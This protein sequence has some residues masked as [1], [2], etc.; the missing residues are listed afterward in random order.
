MIRVLRTF[1]LF[2][3]V[4]ASLVSLPTVAHAD[5]L[6]CD[7]SWIAAVGQWSSP[8]DWSDGVPGPTEVACIDLDVGRPTIDVDPVIGAL[9]LEHGI[10]VVSGPR[11]LS[12]ESIELTDATIDLSGATLTST[13]SLTLTGRTGDPLAPE[14]MVLHADASM[15]TPG[16]VVIQDVLFEATSCATDDATSYT[17]NA[18]LAVDDLDCIDTGPGSE[19]LVT[20]GGGS[21]RYTGLSGALDGGGTLSL[22]GRF[23]LEPGS[24][25]TDGAT[26]VTPTTSLE[27]GMS[28]PGDASVDGLFGGATV[29]PTAQ[30][31]AVLG[32]DE[33]I[34]LTN[35]ATAANS[36]FDA[37][38]L[39]DGGMLTFLDAVTPRAVGCVA[40]DSSSGRSRPTR[41]FGGASTSPYEPHRAAVT[42]AGSS[43]PTAGI[44]VVDVLSGWGTVTGTITAGSA[45]ARGGTLRV[46]GGATIA[47][48]GVSHRA[49]SDGVL[50][51][52]DATN[53]TLGNPFRIE[54]PVGPAATAPQGDE[55]VVVPGVQVAPTQVSGTNIAVAA[56]T[57][58]RIRRDTGIL[59]LV[60]GVP[61]GAP[62]A[63][64]SSSHATPSWAK[65]VQVS[66]T[67]AAP[68]GNSP[69]AVYEVS[70]SNDPVTAGTTKV[71][72]TSTSAT[73][74]APYPRQWYVH[75][76]AI[77]ADDDAG[78]V[79]HGG[80]FTVS[81]R[82][83][84][85]KLSAGLMAPVSWSLSAGSA[86]KP[87]VVAHWSAL[88]EGTYDSWRVERRDA[89]AAGTMGPW[90]S[91]L[92]IDT[93]GARAATL[94]LTPGRAT[95]VRQVL[96]NTSGETPS[97]ER[98]TRAPLDDT[99][100]LRSRTFPSL[101]VRGAYRG[102]VAT[103]RRAGATLTARIHAG[104]TTLT[105]QAR[106]CATC[107]SLDVLLAGKRIGTV[108]LVSR[109][110]APA[111][112]LTV[113]LPKHGANTPLVLRTRS[114][115]ITQVDAIGV[116]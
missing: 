54:G 30:I 11:T 40:H 16:T 38:F 112:K 72:T 18:L 68:S 36:C 35:F 20:T 7:T 15:A 10:Y 55:R 97:I 6:V 27:I 3:C 86:P 59:R 92:A 47:S 110:P 77:D 109:R 41:Y 50:D 52:R 60:D 108:S 98:C 91:L 66:W 1:L 24:T 31:S 73:L 17:T 115:A 63:I 22:S 83:V 100:L 104:A 67:A 43:W 9:V 106:T 8:G 101:R 51:L 116:A 96:V 84:P 61:P 105:V 32:A 74:T 78:P 2:T 58:W 25:I 5:P 85:P 88:T 102:T 45:T 46:V 12:V 64:T 28:G 4:C 71:R 23:D 90:R 111:A 93:P 94:R 42:L 34:V 69:V 79:A 76:V 53:Q 87:I 99:N 103:A 13:G 19:A 89:N 39:T 65:E 81:E 82:L 75:V 44:A 107:G 26:V 14:A 29:D 70:L 113:K 114:A 56:G 57:S 95:C 33:A 37:A 80:P 21:I 48:P 49:G 62:S